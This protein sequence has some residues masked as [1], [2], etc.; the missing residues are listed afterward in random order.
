MIYG[1]GTDILE[2]SRIKRT[3][4]SKGFLKRVFSEKE[5]E[6]FKNKNMSPQTIAANFCG[7]EAFFKAIGTG[8]IFSQ[9]S[10]VSVLRDKSGRPYIYLEDEIKKQYDDLLFHITLSHTAEYA[11]AFVTAEKGE[12]K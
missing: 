4:K 2:I 7:K 3:V 1:I 10:K 12:D 9:I 6:L 11:V 5:L 8:I